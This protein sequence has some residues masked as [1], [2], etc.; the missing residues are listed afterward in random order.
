MKDKSFLILIEQLMMIVIF[1]IVSALCIQVFVKANK[2][3]VNSLNRDKAVLIAQNAVESFKAGEDIFFTTKYD[4]NWK[5]IDLFD[6]EYK[7]ILDT[8]YVYSYLH[9]TKEIYIKVI[10]RNSEILFEIKAAR[11]MD[12]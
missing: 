4:E 10:D 11:G 5:E 9:G 6:E 12:I 1:A 8:T 3:S 2:I 7:Y